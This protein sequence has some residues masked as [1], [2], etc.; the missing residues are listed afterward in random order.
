MAN[1]DLF[2]VEDLNIHDRIV[3]YVEKNLD[4]TLYQGDERKIFVEIIT[5]WTVDFLEVLNEQFNQRFAQYAKGKILDA[6]GE[7]ENVERLKPLHSKSIEK[8]SINSPLSFNIVI[9]QGT[10]V[11]ADNEKYFATDSV[12]VIMAGK[13]SVETSI[14]AVEGGANYNGYEVGQI[15]KLV[16]R[17]EYIATVTNTTETTGGDDGEPYPEVDGGIGDQKY[18]ERIRLAKSSK[19]TAGS[20]TLYKYYAKSADAS[21][22]DVEVVSPEAGAIQLIVSCTDGTVPSK[23]ILDK[24]LEVCNAKYIRPLNDKVTAV[25]VEQIEYDIELC[26]YT[27]EDEENTTVQEVE[28]NGG[29]IERYNNWQSEQIGKTINPDRLR[30]EILKSDTKAVGANYVE[31]VKPTYKIL[32]SSQIA[33]WSGKM[34]VTHKTNNPQEVDNET[35]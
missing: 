20:E 12:A 11:T 31:I 27:T 35:I 9:P 15:N 17:V 30:A 16:D 14:S 5:A 8:F 1:I 22:S 24:V 32:S 19:S 3:S 13:T 29:A 21:I 25:G 6:H 10:R 28:G 26:Y 23:E 7:N 4:E 34:N 2:L 33:K 18:Y